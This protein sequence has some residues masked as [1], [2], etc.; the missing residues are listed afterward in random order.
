MVRVSTTTLLLVLDL[1]GVAA[2]AAS[3]ALTGVQ[4]QLDLFGVVFI[5]G[6]TAIGGGFIRDALIGATPVAAL[7]DWRY[8][9][10]P[11]VVGVV[12]FRVH[13]TIAKLARPLLLVDAAGL[14]LFAVAGARKAI[15]RGIGPIGSIGIG[16][17]TAIG[18]G[19]LRDVLVREIPVVL[20]REIYATAALIGATIVIVG[21][22]ANWADTAVAFAAIVVTFLI[23]VISRWRK[24][25]APVPRPSES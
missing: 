23:R 4:K 5:S 19:I 1:V 13:P 25:S 3:G 20:H 8:L 21:D 11:A 14:G 12:V 16:M 17:V 9:V 6:V 10:T 15:E 24:W 7:S 22:R 2:F 18:G